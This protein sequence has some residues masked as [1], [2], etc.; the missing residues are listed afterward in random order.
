[1]IFYNLFFS[2]LHAINNF[3]NLVFLMLLL[4]H[5]EFLSDYITYVKFDARSICLSRHE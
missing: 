3:I 1:M 2:F 4:H 5:L